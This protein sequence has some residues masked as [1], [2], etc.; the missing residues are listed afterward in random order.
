MFDKDVNQFCWNLYFS[1]VEYPI[2]LRLPAGW[3]KDH[4]IDE[5]FA[6]DGAQDPVPGEQ[7]LSSSFR[8]FW[9]KV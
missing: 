4:K 2:K 5:C 6:K 3:G 1:Y 7:K 8:P 9:S